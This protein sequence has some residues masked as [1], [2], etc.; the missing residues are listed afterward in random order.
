MHGL[1]TR[2]P[3]NNNNINKWSQE[4]D[5]SSQDN[6]KSSQTN[7]KT[8]VNNTNF[9]SSQ[10]NQNFNELNKFLKN[11]EDTRDKI[12]VE[13]ELLK[14]EK[15]SSFI[16]FFNDKM[17]IN[18]KT[19]LLNKYINFHCIIFNHNLEDIIIIY[20]F[21]NIIITNIFAHQLIYLNINNSKF[22]SANFEKLEDKYIIKI[23]KSFISEITED[24]LKLSLET[25][26]T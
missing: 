26:L 5:K 20:P 13:L 17:D 9:I 21:G 2:N 10:N 8:H 6:T 1:L 25:I 12:L 23:N 4:I 24:K 16:P 15:I 19:I 3:K 14:L 22:I 11:I 18:G 7:L